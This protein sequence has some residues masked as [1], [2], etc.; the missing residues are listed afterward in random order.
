MYGTRRVATITRPALPGVRQI[1]WRFA[2][3]WWVRRE[4]GIPADRLIRIADVRELAGDQAWVAVTVARRTVVVGLARTPG[5]SGDP[6]PAGV[7]ERYRL[8]YLCDDDGGS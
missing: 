8:L 5:A 2:A 7:A 6:S 1:D 3:A 4:L